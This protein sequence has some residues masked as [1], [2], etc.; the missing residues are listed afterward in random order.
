M[1]APSYSDSNEKLIE[2][3]RAT[4]GSSGYGSRTFD[5]AKAILDV[6]GQE[7]VVKQTRSLMYATWILASA[8]IG[9]VLATI[10]LVFVSL[11]H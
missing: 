2:A 9:L 6:K 11:H 7:D 10:A 8:T 1:P 4:A 5:I 3:L